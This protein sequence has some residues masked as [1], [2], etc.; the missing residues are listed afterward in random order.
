MEKIDASKQTALA[1]E[2][3]RRQAVDLRKKCMSPEEIGEIT[4]V[5]QGMV[6]R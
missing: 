2:E 4:N 6:C 3:K 1:K 5:H